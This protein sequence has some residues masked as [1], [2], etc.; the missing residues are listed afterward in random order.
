MGMTIAEKIFS[1]KNIAGKNVTAGDYVDAK[2]DGAMLYITFDLV[3]LNLVNAGMK[4]G[5]PYVWDCEKVYYIMDHFQPAPNARIAERNRLG[6]KQAYDLDLK[7]FHESLPSVGHQA[8]C[9]FGYVRPGELIVGID[10]HSTMYGALNAAGTGIGEADMAYALMYGELWFQVPESIKIEL[11]GSGRKYPI[12]K[13]II[14]YLAGK[15]GDDFAQYKSIEFCGTEV[16]KMPLSDRFCLSTHSVEV[17]AK[18]GFFNFDDKVKKY[19]NNRIDRPFEVVDADNDAKYEKTIIVDVDK[20]DFYVAKPHQFG[21]TVPVDEIVGRKIDQAIIGSC[22][23]GRFED[24][25]IAA[26]LLEGKKIPKNIR[27]LIQP[28][29]W[30]IYRQCLNRG[31]ITKLI[32]SGVQFLEPGCG[33]C[34]SMQGYIGDGEVCI[35]SSTRNYKGRLGSTNAEIY[36]GGPATVAVS[37]LKGEITNPKEALDEIN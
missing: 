14:L 8:A 32:D 26:K 33:V 21:N 6:R 7:Y 35:T 23:N 24:I 18:F 2:I 15:Y 25:L 28:A 22:A 5:L 3:Y 30:D 31:I 9:D 13:D 29:S 34:Q 12:A 16:D 37:A 17:G 36:L 27:F 19:I 20:L 10:S 1:K 11:S 4:N